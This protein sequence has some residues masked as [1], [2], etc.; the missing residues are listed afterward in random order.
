MP[1]KNAARIYN[2]TLG[3]VHKIEYP[4]RPKPAEPTGPDLPRGYFGL[5]A[6]RRRIFSEY[7]MHIVE[8]HGPPPVFDIRK[9]HRNA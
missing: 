2:Q 1:R 5:T 8:R 9:P 7:M 3:D 4:A 6:P